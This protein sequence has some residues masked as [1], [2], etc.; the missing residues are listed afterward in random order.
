MIGPAISP[1]YETGLHYYC[2]NKNNV[3][4]ELFIATI[5][6]SL[7]TRRLFTSKEI[8]GVPDYRPEIY[9]QFI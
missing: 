6:L 3:Q 2:G 1:F 9:K 8:T 4:E 7:A 5:D